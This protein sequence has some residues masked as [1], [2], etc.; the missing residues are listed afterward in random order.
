MG[1]SIPFVL[2]RGGTSKG[3]FLRAEDVPTDRDALTDL[4]LDLF[5]SPDRRQIDGLGGAD[6]L[7]SKAAIIGKPVRSDSDVSYLFGQVGT[8]RA[9]VDFNLNCGNLLAAVGMY[10]IEEGLVPPNEGVTLVRVHNLNTDRIVRV[11]VP[12]HDGVPQWRGEFSIGGV[13]GFGAPISLDFSHATGAI[14]GR[15]LP[16]GNSLDIWEIPEAGSIELSIVDGAN[17]AVYVHASSLGM[18]GTESPEEI[19]NN[20]ALKSRMDAIRRAVAYRCGLRQYW[21]ARQAASTPMLIVVSEPADYLT[22]T[23]GERIQADKFHLAVRQFA[24]G[25]ASKTLAATLTA[26]SGLACAIAGTLPHRLVGQTNSRSPGRIAFGHPSGIAY[27][28]IA[29][30][31]KLCIEQLRVM[32]TARRIAGGRVFLKYR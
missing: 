9:E 21:D 1:C 22:C 30:S 11:G 14:T 23:Q 6:K 26:T 16:T 10:A 12:V 15:V 27:I 7:T 2:M 24:S 19:D 13:P 29:V 5:G 25:S 32:R 17:M 8:V 28:D 20:A 4:L 18:A 31:E 3:I